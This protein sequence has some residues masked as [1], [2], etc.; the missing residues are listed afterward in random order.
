[1]VVDILREVGIAAR[2]GKRAGPKTLPGVATG[3]RSKTIDAK[4]HMG[5]TPS[6]PHEA[7]DNGIYRAPGQTLSHSCVPN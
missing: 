3:K 6:T 5:G 4:P 2:Q 7:E 1:M